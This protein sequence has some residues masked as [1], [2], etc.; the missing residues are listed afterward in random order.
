MI[1]YGPFGKFILQT[2]MNTSSVMS[3]YT[4]PMPSQG[5]YVGSAALLAEL[6]L[7]NPVGVISEDSTHYYLTFDAVSPDVLAN[8]TGAAAW[9]RITDGVGDLVVDLDVTQTAGSGAIKMTDVNV[10][11]GGTFTLDSGVISIAK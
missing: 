2:V 8:N 11:Q 3:F 10:Y 5:G 7:T 6:V 9:A 4:A 1:A